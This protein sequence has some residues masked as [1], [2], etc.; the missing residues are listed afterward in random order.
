MVKSIRAE[1]R[2]LKEGS[3]SAGQ[4]R[5]DGGTEAVRKMG[6][7]EEPESRPAR[8]IVRRNPR[9]SPRAGFTDV[10]RKIHGH[11]MYAVDHASYDPAPAAH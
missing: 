7:S 4:W 10:S 1:V 5:C 9:L 8:R 3:G 11:G 2:F 6:S